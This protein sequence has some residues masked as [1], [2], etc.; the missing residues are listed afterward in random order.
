MLQVIEG[1]DQGR[2]FPLPVGEPQ[3]IGRSTEAFPLV[4]MSIS[5][6]HA[7]LTPDGPDSVSYTHLT[8]PT[9]A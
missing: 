4:D 2:V 7:E 5:R 9:K 1:P 3:L 6:R 8:L